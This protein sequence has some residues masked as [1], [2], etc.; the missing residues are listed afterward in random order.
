MELDGALSEI[1]PRRAEDTLR[2]DEARYRLV[3]EESLQGI[4]IHLDGII[5]YANRSA[6]HMFGDDGPHELIGREI[7]P[8]I[9]APE[10]HAP[11][12]LRL[13]AL[14][15]GERLAPHPGWRGIRKD[16]STIWVMAGANLVS[17]GGRPAVVAFYSDITERVHAE[18]A[19]RESEAKLRESEERLR[20]AAEAAGFGIYDRDL[21]AGARIWSPTLKAIFGFPADEMVTDEMV[22][23]H[24]HP[25]DRERVLEMQLASFDPASTGEFTSEHRI[26]RR[27]GATRWVQL[28]GKAYF[29]GE[30]KQRRAVRAVGVMMDITDRKR[31]DE[32][33]RDSEERYRTLTEALPQHIWT[34]TADLKLV[35][36][37]RRWQ[38]YS[39][40]TVETY[41]AGGGAALVHHPDDFLRVRQK[42]AQHG[43]SGT[44]FEV[45]M[46][47][48]RH[49]GL[50]RWFLVRYIPVTD[51]D[52][53]LAMW[54]GTSTD[55][56]DRKLAEEAVESSRRMLQ[57]VLDNVPQGVFWKDRQSR[58]LGC[59]RV[60]AKAQGFEDP[61]QLIGLDDRQFPG[62]TPAQADSFIQKDREVMESNTPE[63]G[64]LEPGTRA[65][66]V[67]VWMET[68][69]VPMHDA[70][71]QVIG[72]LG[73]WQDVT[74]RVRAEEERRK[75]EAQIQHTQKLESLGVLAGGIAHDF[76][77]LLTSMLGYSDLAQRALAPDSAPRAFI[78]EVVKG[79]RRAADLT[80]QML[81]YSG[82]GRFV[83]QPI[84]ISA[85]V[86]DMSRL[87]EISTSKKCV[88]KCN[89][90]ANLPAFAAD[91]AQ[92]R[93]IIMNLILNASE[94]IGERS[95]VIAVSTGVMQCDRAYLSETYL[96]E[97]LPEGLYVYLEVAD[98]GCGMSEETREKIFD[99]FFTTKFTGRGLGLAAVLG[100]VR[101]HKGAIKVYS[102][103]GKGTTFK[104]LF[105]AS[106]QP[107]CN[108]DER[109]AEAKEWR[110]HGTVLVVDDEESVRGMAQHMM[111]TMGFTVLT[112]A[113]GREGVEVFRKDAECIRVVLLDLTMPH[114]D[115]DE[116]F[117]EMRRIRAD[118]CA[119]LS[120]GYNEQTATDRF[121]GKGL[122]GFI[123]KPY[124]YSDLME[125]VRRVLEK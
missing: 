21:R 19:A 104:V 39:G 11:L 101:G 77:N 97:N 24:L 105:P 69:K 27:D 112:A 45:E 47:L 16:G 37:N 67:S 50:Y 25:D 54:V 49:D 85:L 64:I 30:G 43:A 82:K 92:I 118:V 36:V 125:I 51:A 60:V 90:T 94:A 2:E 114:M 52:G 63:Y 89:F 93:Q 113:D 109:E 99:P 55:I 95:G 13:A 12:Q 110:G 22:Q 75:L 10:W 71:G 120:S 73:T 41:N 3:V 78:D 98:T 66:G 107:A 46:R 14:Y 6:A 4:L 65:D 86:E 20:L 35:Y 115:G 121:A 15:R 80:Q 7:W 83:V 34:L 103:P 117:R 17:W 40:L 81:A 38:E 111:Q 74:E 68:C 88:L 56:H 91:A 72:V 124:R 42:I 62:T 26:L 53:L 87:L 44:D 108:T 106:S 18:Q 1:A 100:I 28:L 96:D 57:L 122:A 116:A 29:D 70:A 84:D 123:Q 9:V 79:A 58:Y 31:A 8:T 48:R 23:D 59:N 33:L 32:A 5:V 102:E 76:N 119:I 61:A